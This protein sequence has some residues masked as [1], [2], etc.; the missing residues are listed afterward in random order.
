M[1]LANGGKITTSTGAQVDYS[2]YQVVSGSSILKK[3]EDHNVSVSQKGYAFTGWKLYKTATIGVKAP[4]DAE[5]DAIIAGIG[6]ASNLSDVTT[7][8]AKKD[9]KMDGD[10]PADP[11]VIL[12]DTY[13]LVAQWAP[14]NY[15]VRMNANGGS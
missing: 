2:P 6:T 11:E 5:Y 14:G 1:Y 15:T 3:I 10:K 7:Q 9:V 4:G 12:Q 13:Y 8:I